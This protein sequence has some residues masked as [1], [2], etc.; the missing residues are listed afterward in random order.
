LSATG[1]TVKSADGFTETFR[2]DAATK[3]R[4]KGRLAAGDMRVGDRVRVVGVKDGKVV[5]AK[6]ILDRS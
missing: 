5:T 6:R 1:I 2:I 4:G 3:V